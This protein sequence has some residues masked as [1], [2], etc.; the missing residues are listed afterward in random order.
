MTAPDVVY[1]P[2]VPVFGAVPL[3]TTKRSDPDNARLHTP[4]SPEINDA[5]TTAPEVVYSPTV[6]VP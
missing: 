2:I 4:G 3:L 1:S 6:P 5:L